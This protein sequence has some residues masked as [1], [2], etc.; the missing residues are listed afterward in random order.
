MRNHACAMVLQAF[1][2]L[3][4]MIVLRIDCISH[5]ALEPLPGAEDLRQPLFGNDISVAV[6]SDALFDLDPKVMQTRAGPLQ[7]FQELRMGK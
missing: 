5:Q 3:A 6:D 4:E 2:V 1:K 7:G